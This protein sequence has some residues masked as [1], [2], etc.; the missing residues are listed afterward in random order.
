MNAQRTNPVWWKNEYD[1]AWE[2][3]KAALK[4]DWEQTKHDFG[5]DE[6]DIKQNVTDTI[7][8]SAGSD[9][10]PP[11]YSVPFDEQEDAY[12]FGYAARLHYGSEYDAWGDP[13]EKRLKADW[14][15]ANKSAK[16]D[17]WNRHRQAVRYAYE[18]ENE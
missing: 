16:A 18:Y 3:T 12:R 9:P 8:Q 17:E 11:L 15:G 4:R 2:R 5:G 13:L 7:A 14:L 6:P 1:S 10:V